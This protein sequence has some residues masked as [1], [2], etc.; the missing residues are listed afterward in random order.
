[1]KKTLAMILAMLMLLSCT[2]LAEEDL[3]AEPWTLSWV[4]WNCGEIVEGNWAEKQ[5]EEKFNV[6]ITVSRIDL[7]NAE[8]KNLMLA[9]GEMPEAGWQMGSDELYLTQGITRLIPEE[10]IRKYAPN[11]AAML[12]ENP[13]G[14]QY[15][16]EPE[17]GDYMALTGRA[18]TNAMPILCVR[19]DWLEN[20]GL[21]IPE[22][23]DFPGMEG[24]DYEGKIFLTEY[25]YTADELYD[26]MYAFTYNDPDGNGLQDTYGAQTGGTYNN[27]MWGA[28]INM[29]GFQ[30]NLSWNFNFPSE[31]GLCDLHFV[32][33]QYKEMLSYWSKAYAEGL[34]DKEYITLSVHACW[35]KYAN[36]RAGIA[37]S[38]ANWDAV[39]SYA[40][41]PPYGPISSGVN[42]GAKML[43]MPVP[44]ANDGSY[45]VQ[46]Y[47]VTNYNYNFVV[48]ED[49]DDEKLAKILT[50]FDY[51]NFDEEAQIVYRIGQ[52]GVHF[53]YKNPET[54]SGGYAFTENG[55]VGKDLGLWAF[56]SNYVQTPTSL[57]AMVSEN[58]LTMNSWTAEFYKDH[59]INPYKHNMFYN[60]GTEQYNELRE[61]YATAV[62][63]V[64]KEYLTAVITGE[65]NLEETWDEYLA[66]LDAC[67]Y[68]E[69]RLA[70]GSLPTFEQFIAGDF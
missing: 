67:G 5:L 46:N 40:A 62:D 70:Y 9:S 66:E 14:W 35:E 45:G 11:Y 54:K 32:T 28:L 42:E 17:T 12:D 13:I 37:T 16:K 56:N 44:T 38:L 2:A 55:Y 43:V 59:I 23:K 60:D 64:A 58:I 24:T 30:A 33:P 4:G 18:L 19:L 51:L 57:R 69:I 27:Q 26:I 63:T 6:E 36:G 47:S 52:E 10:M 15:H 34:L 1:M 41:R 31:D 3:F 8:Q 48:R 20:L 68:Q 22:Y 61:L 49:V 25:Q 7:S 53:N 39:P 65:K 50:L 21:K 29:F